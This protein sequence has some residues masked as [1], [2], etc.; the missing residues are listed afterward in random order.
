[1]TDELLGIIQLVTNKSSEIE[2]IIKNT[3]FTHFFSKLN[4]AFLQHNRGELL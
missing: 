1:M 3:G 2:N 4:V